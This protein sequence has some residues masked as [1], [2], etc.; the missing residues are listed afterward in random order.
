MDAEKILKDLKLL[1]LASNNK[2]TLEL[3]LEAVNLG[4]KIFSYFENKHA[5][6]S[7]NLVNLLQNSTLVYEWR[8]E[9]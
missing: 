5:D 1:T 3:Q 2:L 6:M 7:E 9:L 4:I 8:L